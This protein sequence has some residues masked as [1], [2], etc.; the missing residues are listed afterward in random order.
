M[1][2]F[3][4]KIT[5]RD[6]VDATLQGREF[7]HKDIYNFESEISKGDHVFI[8]LSGDKSRI[9]WDQGL[10]AYGVVNVAPYDKGYSRENKK[11]FKIKIKPVVILKTPIPP[12]ETKLHK[13]YQDQ[14]YDVP[15]VGA[16]HFPNQAIARTEGEGA[17]ALFKLMSE[18][19]PSILEYL[20]P[21]F[22]VSPH[23]LDN[24]SSSRSVITQAKT[25]L[26]FKPFLLLAG[27]SG[28]GKTR[29]VR[30]QASASAALYHQPERSNYCL[31]PVRPDWHEPS[32]LLGYISRIGTDGTRYVVTDLLRFMVKAWKHAVQSATAEKIE[33]KPVE[34]ICPFWL[35]LDEM[36]LAPVEQ[37]FADYLSILETRKWENGIYSCDPILKSDTISQLE[38]EGKTALWKDLELTDD[39][40]VNQGLKEYFSKVGIP[41][42]PNLIVAGTVNMDETTHGFSR[43]VI[44]R[45]LTL[46]FGEFYPND[47]AEFFEPSIHA[48]TLGFPT[49]KQIAK[50]DLAS[51]AADPDGTKTRD[52]LDGV[53]SR[54]KGTPF[55]LAYRALNEALLAVV[56]FNPKDDRELQAVWDDFLMMKVLPRIEGDAEKLGFDGEETGLLNDL[57]TALKGL[58]PA[59]A[60]TERP[61][62]F[63]EKTADGGEVTTGCRTLDKLG[64]MQKRLEKNSFTSFWP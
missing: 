24:H 19:D 10:V 5:N 25:H 51:V 44:D 9:D 30:E 12:K 61:D 4:V 27:I 64:Q 55:E 38:E 48:K 54:L 22:S 35:C 16:N 37:Y 36:N 63:R 3:L 39:N 56:C 21:Q 23:R 14:L 8:Y 46:D 11:Y 52:F 45:A 1:K 17:V 28:T 59:I 58:L 20:P 42:P 47:Y 13:K 7:V 53:N 15:Y 6:N 60:G 29:F 49:L 41:L 43:K 31:V 2:A 34:T 32:D 57:S 40:S 26:L 62:L 50:A 18:Y 33:C